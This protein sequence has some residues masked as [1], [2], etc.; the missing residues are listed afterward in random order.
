M[1]IMVIRTMSW[2]DKV[3]TCLFLLCCLTWTLAGALLAQT[4]PKGTFKI[5]SETKSP[6]PDIEGTDV[7]DVVL[8]TTDP[9]VKE[10]LKGF[11]DEKLRADFGEAASAEPLGE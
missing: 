7:A 11:K 1:S 9:D 8:S 10:L 3:G 4:S 6:A 5:E 2:Q